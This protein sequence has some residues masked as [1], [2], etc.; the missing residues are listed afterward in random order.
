MTRARNAKLPV[1]G[2]VILA[3]ALGSCATSAADG[4]QSETAA[5]GWKGDRPGPPDQAEVDQGRRIAER[6]C[7]SCHAIDRKSASP[8]PGAPPLRDV[9]ALYEADNLAYRFI[10]GMRVGHDDMP[11]FD[12]DV[13]TADAL[14][15]Y[16]GTISGPSE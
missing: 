3:V 4:V 10:E 12:F 16:I 7:A 13:R 9:L 8:R 6:T 2:A 14:I 11:L 1:L 15:A 5:A